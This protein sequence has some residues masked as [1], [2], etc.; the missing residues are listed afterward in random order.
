MK[1]RQSGEETVF[2]LPIIIGSVIATLVVSLIIFLVVR[3]KKSSVK[4]DAEKQEGNTEESKKLNK[5]TEE[6]IKTESK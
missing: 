6:I 3:K 2:L 5:A 4:Y 1:E